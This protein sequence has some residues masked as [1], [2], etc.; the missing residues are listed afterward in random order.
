MNNQSNKI[1]KNLTVKDLITIGI[2]SALFFIFT[3]I[4]GGFFAINPVLTFYMPIG[5]S[6]LCGPI[7][8]LL[9]A[10][11]RKHWSIT[12]LGFI[13]AFVWYVTGMH[14]ALW[15]GYLGMSILAD[16]IAGFGKYRSIKFNILSYMVLSLAGVYTYIVYF[17]DPDRWAGTML[18]GGTEQS[19]I[20]A[21]R[22]SSSPWILFVIIFGTL[23]ISAF[24]AWIGKKMLKKHFE[25][26]GIIE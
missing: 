22:A 16:V 10:K 26:A 13:M 23:L 25:K 24:S 2:F 12:I 20:D 18:K 3:L 9:I 1:S 17:I 15:L 19:Y 8:L 11:V 14:W 6:L 4:G 5:S 21:M 7:Y